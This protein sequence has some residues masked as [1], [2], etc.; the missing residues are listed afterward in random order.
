MK[1]IFDHQ[2][3]ASQKYGGVSKYFAEVISRLPENT[4]EVTARLSNNEYSRNYRLFKQIPFLPNTGFRG[5]GRIMAELGKPRSAARLLRGGYDIVHQTNFDPYL[6]KY[7]G[8][9]P[10]VT[11]YHDINFLTPN[12]FNPRMKRLQGQ[13]LERADGIVAISR[14]TKKDL[15]EFFPAIDESKIKVIYH[16]IDT[17]VIPKGLEARIFEKPYILYVGLRHLFKNFRAFAKAFASIA[18]RH[19]DL[20]VVCTRK[21]FSKE[22][23]ESF[24]QTG[25]SERMH[26]IA[27]DE[28]TLNRLYRDAELFVFPS[29]Y[30]G[31]GMPVLEAMANGCPTVIANTSC[32]PE[33]GGNACIYFDPLQPDSIAAVIEDVLMHEELR[34]SLRERGFKRAAGF[35]WQKCADAHFDFYK[36]LT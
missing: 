16:G 1:I 35:S 23:L 27:A 12:N 34:N 25:I 32:F 28:V 13:S 30:E 18:P 33:I 8:R 14:N 2:I 17:P 3:F 24:R 10:M 15:L 26:F 9:K 29:L 4:W 5:K 19:P 31:F 6:F 36:S 20:Q 11:T 22:E 7:I 21:D